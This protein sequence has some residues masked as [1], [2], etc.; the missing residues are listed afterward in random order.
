MIITDQNYRAGQFR[1][2]KLDLLNRTIHETNNWKITPFIG[3]NYFDINLRISCI[4]N[5]WE[6]GSYIT[7]HMNKKDK[8][9]KAS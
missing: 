3:E 7:V 9:E 2:D 1:L 6:T 4:L 5:W 8:E